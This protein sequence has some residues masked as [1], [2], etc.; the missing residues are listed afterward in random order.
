MTADGGKPQV[1]QHVGIG[2]V[3]AGAARAGRRYWWRILLVAAAVSVLTALAEIAV[4]EFV[5]RADISIS[6]V[7]DLSASAVSLVGA[8]L[9]SGFLCRLV[10]RS[11]D[12]DT[13]IR[14]VARSL[15]WWRL[16]RADLLVSLLVAIGLLALV[17]PGLIVFTKLA[18]TGPVIEIER[19]PV[20]AALR[21]SARLVRGHFWAVALLATLPVALS[22]EID[23]IGPRPTSVPAVL[24]LLAIRGGGGA[25]AQAAVGLII[26]NLCSR[27]MT[28][29]QE[30]AGRRAAG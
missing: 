2:A 19:K 22:S 4:E 30:S 9:V 15:P 10:R 8:V 18:V 17:I 6:L 12:E 7:A 25:V 29:D 14:S 20:V 5:D 28:L 16:I 1:R 27:L 23:V 21:R 13:S 26:G 11:D 3:L 24:E